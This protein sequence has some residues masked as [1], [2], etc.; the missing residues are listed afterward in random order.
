[1]A[2]DGS[3]SLLDQLLGYLLLL[4]NNKCKVSWLVVVVLVDRLLDLCDCAVLFKVCLEV[5]LADSLLW[6]F[7]DK[8]LA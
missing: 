5:L 1:M 7:A 3:G 6:Q 8:D 2:V 4:K